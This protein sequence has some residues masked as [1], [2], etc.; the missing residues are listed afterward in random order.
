MHYLGVHHQALWATLGKSP[1]VVALSLFNLLCLI[2]FISERALL[3][4]YWV[5]THRLV[6]PIQYI[7]VHLVMV[8]E[9]TCAAVRRRP[10]V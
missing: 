7:I 8:G 6:Q 10:R 5:I 3:R 9:I 2:L 4:H 1:R